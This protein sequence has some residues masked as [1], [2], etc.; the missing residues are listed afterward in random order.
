MR[1]SSDELNEIDC[2]K[3]WRHMENENLKI[4]MKMTKQ[5]MKT[6]NKN[7]ND[8]LPHQT[9]LGRSSGQER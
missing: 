8:E 6:T 2:F 4:K 3:I 1:C 7:E 9:P 5:K